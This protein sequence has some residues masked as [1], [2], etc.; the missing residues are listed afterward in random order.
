MNIGDYFK[1]DLFRIEKAYS[2]WQAVKLQKAP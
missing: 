1:A 2:I